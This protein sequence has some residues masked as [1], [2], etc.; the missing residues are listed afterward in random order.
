MEQRTPEWHQA[1]LGKVT[2]S[3]LSDVLAKGRGGGPSA[4]RRNYMAQLVAEKLTGTPTEGFS[5]S[6][7][8]WGIDTEPMAREA[9]ELLKNTSIVE[10]GFA[11]HLT[12]DGTGASPD[13]LI[14]EVGMV[15][16]KCPNTATHIDNLTDAPIKR[17]YQMQMQWQMECTAREWCDFVSFDPRMPMHLQM[18]I[19]RVKRDEKII[20]EIKEGVTAFIQEMAELIEK[21]DPQIKVETA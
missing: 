10:L 19:V 9:Y 13:G 1:R 4:T 2:A 17:D 14:G 12:I 18:H 15:E 6:A 3:R 5:S 11:P 16:F 21:I 8:Q 7:M 20:T